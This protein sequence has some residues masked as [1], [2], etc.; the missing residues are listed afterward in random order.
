VPERAPAAPTAK[1]AILLV[2]DDPAVRRM[3]KALFGREG[4]TVDVARSAQHAL[5]LAGARVYDLI[6][7]D[8]QAR[9]RD[10]LFVTR[11]V[12]TLPALKDRVLVATGDVR[13]GSDDALARLGLR[14][15][16]KPFNL[17]DLRDEAAGHPNTARFT[18]PPGANLT[19]SRSNSAR[20]TTAPWSAP[21][22]E[23]R[24]AALSTRHHGTSASSG[25]AERAQPTVRAAPG[26]PASRAT[27]PYVA[28]RPL[29]MWRTTR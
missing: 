8:A 27:I 4:H 11:L 12:E 21:E 22:S 7:A 14:Y 29:G 28:T 25:S 5:D 13:P 17:R 16:R 24:P 20:W 18:A 2:D 9:A 3:V 6:L 1:R 10:R 19:P 26:R 15:V 23:I